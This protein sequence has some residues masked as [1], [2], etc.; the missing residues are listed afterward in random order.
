MRPSSVQR[1]S[2]ER[3]ASILYCQWPGM[4]LPWRSMC[5]GTHHRVG[6]FPTQWPGTRTPACACS[7]THHSFG[8]F[9]AQWPGTRTSPSTCSGIH[10]WSIP[11]PPVQWP[12]TQST[13]SQWPETHWGREVPTFAQCPGI[14]PSG[15]QCPGTHS[16]SG[17]G[18]VRMATQRPSTH[19]YGPSDGGASTRRHSPCA[20]THARPV[21]GGSDGSLVVAQL[22]VTSHVKLNSPRLRHGPPVNGPLPCR[23]LR[24]LAAVS[25]VLLTKATVQ[26]LSTKLFTPWQIMRCRQPVSLA[27]P[28]Y[29]GP[30]AASTP[31][32]SHSSSK[33]Q[34]R[35]VILSNM[36]NT[37]SLPSPPSQRAR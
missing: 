31:R 22:T 15:P 28:L 36:G 1:E 6:G 24:A 30:H 2:S 34:A 12:G 16:V 18:G 11:G 5:S 32:A 9:P 20:C 23:R 35:N 27:R 17:G 26:T 14:Q 33:P 8:S 37:F 4:L 25:T 7:G 21:G 19:S 10:H 13:P 29:H 3:F